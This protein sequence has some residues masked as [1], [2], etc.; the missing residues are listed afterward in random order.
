MSTTDSKQRF[1]SRVADYVRARPGYPPGVLQLF[2][3]EMSLTP[4][5]IVAD[6]G[7]GTGISAKLFLENGN[8]VH[9]VEPNEPMR[10]AAEKFLGSY[11]G[12]RSINASAEATT[13]ADD[14]VD[15][16][17]CAQAFHWFDPIR[18]KIEF[19]RILR[20][21]GWIALMWNERQKS[22]SRFLERYEALLHTYGTDYHKI[23]HENLGEQRIG[24]FLGDK[25]RIAKFPNAQHV[26]LEGLRARLFS[27]SY[28]P[29][30]GQPRHDELSRDVNQLF[31]QEQKNGIVT[32][33]YETQVYYARCEPV[34]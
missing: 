34:D 6:V 4:A 28:V 22:G 31:A 5:S 11:A 14:S 13:L 25:M 16:I 17:V 18:T 15:F 7:S 1:S 19:A 8:T 21:N 24:E 26:D 33:G 29:L 20:D 32:I 3:D 2:R 30:E 23:R 12:F 10:E 9:C 27:S